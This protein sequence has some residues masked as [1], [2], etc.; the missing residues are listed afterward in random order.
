MK[1][2][3]MNHVLKGV[4]VVMIQDLKLNQRKRAKV[5]LQDLDLHL[6]HQQVPKGVAVAVVMIQDLELQRKGGK[7]IHLGLGLSLHLQHQ[8]QKLRV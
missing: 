5:G 2:T 8:E 7:V 3:V 4:A 1:T 6:L